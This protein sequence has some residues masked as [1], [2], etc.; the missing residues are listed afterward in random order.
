[1]VASGIKCGTGR[2]YTSNRYASHP[3]KGKICGVKRH[4]SGGKA[5]VGNG[6]TKRL[7]GKGLPFYKGA[8]KTIY[9]TIYINTYII[10]A[11]TH[12]FWRGRYALVYLQT[13]LICIVYK[14]SG[15]RVGYGIALIVG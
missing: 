8:R 9:G 11:N 2:A 15:G 10:A 12:P 4:T 14:E 6:N 5:A 1:L 13:A 7:G 3:A